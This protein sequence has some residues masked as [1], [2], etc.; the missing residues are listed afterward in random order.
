MHALDELAFTA[1]LLHAFEAAGVALP[2]L[3]QSTFSDN[4]IEL[5][6]G[7]PEENCP[8]PHLAE[9]G[10]HGSKFFYNPLGPV[11]A[12]QTYHSLANACAAAANDFKLNARTY[13]HDHA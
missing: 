7:E 11:D 2:L 4:I 6:G 5:W 10:R 8:P 13:C 3:R 9:L 1:A 12:Q